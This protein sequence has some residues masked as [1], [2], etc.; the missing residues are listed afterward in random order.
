MIETI[1]PSNTLEE[2]YVSRDCRVFRMAGDP[3]AGDTTIYSVFPGVTVVYSNF[4]TDRCH[5]NLRYADRVIS[6]DYCAE[7]RIEWAHEEGTVCYLWEQD[8]QISAQTDHTNHYGFPTSHY[9]GV[10]VNFFT[11]EAA[12]SLRRHFPSFDIDLEA[13]WRLVCRK[14]DYFVLRSEKKLHSIFSDLYKTADAVRIVYLRIKIMELLI[15]LGAMPLDENTED[16]PYFKDTH[17]KKVRQ[18]KEH[19]CA[20]A[21]EK[22][23]LRELAGQ[24]DIPLST[25][26][27][28]FKSMYG[29]SIHAFVKQYRL[30]AAMQLLRSTDMSITRVALETG[31]ENPS[32]FIS[33]FKEKYSMTPRQSRKDFHKTEHF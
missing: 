15:V 12:R 11:E 25:L 3:E 14:K 17:V 18:I 26:T 33:A 24:F 32:K 4:H 19:L 9:H 31:Y 10:T 27:A 6:L 21:A 30:Q 8:V 5:S 22:I 13:L 20:H 16:K 29:Q 1:L 23:T 28:C 7:G 2:E